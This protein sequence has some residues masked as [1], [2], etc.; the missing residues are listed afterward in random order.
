MAISECH[1]ILSQG[2]RRGRSHPP[3]ALPN[4]WPAF[5]IPKRGGGKSDMDNRDQSMTDSQDRY[6]AR[7]AGV[8]DCFLLWDGR[9]DAAVYGI[10]L[11]SKNTVE[12]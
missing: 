5:A 9:S 1:A 8:P 2:T 3:E 7:P 10:Q 4:G 12:A 11:S 6:F